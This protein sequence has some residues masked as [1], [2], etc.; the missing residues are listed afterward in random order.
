MTESEI[1]EF[2]SRLDGARILIGSEA[3]GT[4]EVAWG[5]TFC[6]YDP[7]GTGDQRMPFVTIVSNDTPEWD[8]VSDRD[9]PYRFRVNV[10][11]GRSGSL[12]STR[13]STMS[14]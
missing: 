12:W 3:E 13:L 1:R 9:G 8:E 7:D 6:F 4:P 11:V 2:L 10:A 14:P 5:D